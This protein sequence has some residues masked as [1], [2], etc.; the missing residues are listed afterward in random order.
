MRSSPL[1]E[2]AHPPET[3]DRH[4]RGFRIHTPEN[5]VAS[6][7]EDDIGALFSHSNSRAAATK[8]RRCC[9]VSRPNNPVISSGKRWKWRGSPYA[10]SNV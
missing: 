1:K 2:P 9:H 4:L 6:T 3:A 5:P 10:V 7:P 8:N